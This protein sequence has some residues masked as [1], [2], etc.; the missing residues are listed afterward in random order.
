MVHQP[1]S[2]GLDDVLGLWLPMVSSVK[3]I[4]HRQTTGT[5]TP[6]HTLVLDVQVL[7]FEHIRSQ[8]LKQSRTIFGASRWSW[9][10]FGCFLTFWTLQSSSQFHRPLRRAPGFQQL[11]E[12][13]K[14]TMSR[15]PVN[16][17]HHLLDG[18][19][20][21]ASGGFLQVEA[22]SGHSQ[23]LLSRKIGFQI[24]HHL[25]F[26]IQEVLL[27]DVDHVLLLEVPLELHGLED[28]GTEFGRII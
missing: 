8:H 13:A 2:E 19:Q 21:L 9:R 12:V 11:L 24:N 3:N 7:I 1:S 14:T 23:N 26:H 17:H 28:V 27:S 5:I 18:F 6:K 15:S 10:R 25:G 16:S 4:N 20:T 22:C